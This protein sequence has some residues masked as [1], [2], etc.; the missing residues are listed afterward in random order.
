MVRSERAELLK[1]VLCSEDG[2]LIGSC[3]S[4]MD[5]VSEL[6]SLSDFMAWSVRVV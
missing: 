4:M 5:I 3:S 2:V 6:V 1:Y